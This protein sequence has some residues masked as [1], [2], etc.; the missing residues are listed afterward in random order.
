MRAS[1]CL[2]ALLVTSVALADPRP[3]PRAWPEVGLTV[4]VP[5]G[6]DEL[7]ARNPTANLLGTWRREGP[8]ADGP[9]LLQLV[10]LGAIVPQRPLDAR[11]LAELRSSDPYP[12]IDTRERARAFGF[13]LDALV[14]RAT[15]NGH[16]ALRLSTAVPL[17]DD[18]VMVVVLSPASREPEARAVFRE[19]LASCRGQTAWQTPWQHWSARVQRV[20][21]VLAIVAGVTYGLLALT[22]FR[23]RDGWRRARAAALLAT[24][25]L[26]LV[27]AAL[28]PWGQWWP[29]LRSL[30]LAAAFLRHGAKRARLAAQPS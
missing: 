8:R 7:P 21:A 14:G 23:R 11:E 2:A 16:A 15:V 17:V 30:A 5:A 3:R 9:I 25:A 28:V 20:C 12:F 27:V 22:L 26:W 6:F 1:P 18:S 19:V 29:M 24:G 13:D 10:H 4:T